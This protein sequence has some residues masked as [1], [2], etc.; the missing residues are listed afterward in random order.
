MI[1]SYSPKN[2]NISFQGIALTG[3]AE[4]S[5]IRI[6]RNSDVLTEVVG[7]RGELSLTV[8]ADK[9]GEL[10]LELLQTSPSN[11]ALSALLAVMELGGVIPVG[12]FL[13]TDPSGS[14]ITIANNAYLKGTPDIEL[15]KD[16]NSRVWTFGCETLLFTSTPDGFS[17]DIP[18][19]SL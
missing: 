8:V 12:Q 11:L 18:G 2:V 4:D 5:F 6:K 1:N 9:T 3:F 14:N 15:A 17:P 19:F 10:E 13:V 16:Q 7:A